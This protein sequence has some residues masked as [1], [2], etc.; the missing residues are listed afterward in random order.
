MAAFGPLRQITLPT[1]SGR[2]ATV[3]VY[4]HNLLVGL[5]AWC[6]GGRPATSMSDC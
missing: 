5:P 1:S 6:L 2:S 4:D 3:L